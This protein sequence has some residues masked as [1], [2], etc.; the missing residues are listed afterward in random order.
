MMARRRLL[1]VA[2]L[3]LAGCSG[4]A[5]GPAPAGTPVASSPGAPPTS[6]AP[7]SAAPASAAPTAAPTDDGPADD[8]PAETAAFV[9]AVRAKLP[10]VARG[11]RDEEI[12]LVA[13]QACAGLAADLPAGEIVTETRSLG[14]QDA[15]A[16]DQAT[17][18]ELVKLAIDK[19]CR[20]QA[21]RAKDF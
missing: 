4:P 6:A 19:V 17:A 21:K 14:T 1:V 18:R 9:A 7:A 13:E 2:V 11:R 10:A 5:A 20:D 12:A 3:A 16:T 8:D 15:Q